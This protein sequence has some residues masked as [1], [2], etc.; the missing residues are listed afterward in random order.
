MEVTTK[1]FRQS[2]GGAC[3]RLAPA[4]SVLAAFLLS[5]CASQPSSGP[6][7]ANI[8]TTLPKNLPAPAPTLVATGPAMTGTASWYS[9]G[10]GLHHTCSGQVFNGSGMTAASH[11]IPLGTK[12]RVALL[13]N[14]NRS[15][16]VRVN[17]CM[18][19]GRRILDLS[20]AAARQLGIISAGVAEVSVTP[21]TLVAYSR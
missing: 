11:T 20:K 13:N 18:G 2:N 21:V 17:D 8:D 10:P 6:H 3:F 5:A 16:I 14:E 15:I 1:I 7:Q 19:H 12:V 4:A 9:P